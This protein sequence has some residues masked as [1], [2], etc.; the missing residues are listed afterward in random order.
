MEPI[1]PPVP[2]AATNFVTP[3]HAD[4]LVIGP[5]SLACPRGAG[6][7][8]MTPEQPRQP[9]RDVE[10]HEEHESREHRDQFNGHRCLPFNPHAHMRGQRRP[11]RKRGAA[12][13]ARLSPRGEIGVGGKSDLM[14]APVG[15]K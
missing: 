2:R 13:S 12:I 3:G 14:P 15:F 4:D 10:E 5:A 9:E 7:I 6:L 8:A 1:F 11:P